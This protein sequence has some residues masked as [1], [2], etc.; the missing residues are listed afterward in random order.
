M[1]L[2]SCAT[3][4]EIQTGRKLHVQSGAAAGQTWKFERI[5]LDASGE[6]HVHAS[7][8][9][10]KLG[11]IHRGFHPSVFGCEI[12]VDITWRKS[13]GHVAYR[14]WSQVAGYVLAGIF[15][16]G[17]LA[18]YEHFHWSEWIVEFLGL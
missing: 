17:P 3:G 1:K 2:I 4:E 5:A 10:G 14:T 9:G 8:P 6:H 13:V 11:R 16:L 15:A 18:L 7:R 12:S